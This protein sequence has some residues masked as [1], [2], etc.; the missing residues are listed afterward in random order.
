MS[1]AT[2][3]A[4]PIA[5]LALVLAAVGCEFLD[6]PDTF[7]LPGASVRVSLTDD[8]SQDFASAEV[9]ITR[10]YISRHGDD[11]SVVDLLEASEAPQ[12]VDL[13]RLRDNIETMI[14]ESAVPSGRYDK[15]NIVVDA[16]EVELASGRSFL[17][18]TAS[19]LVEPPGDGGAD[20][21]VSLSEPLV[22]EDG[23]MTL[24][25]VEFV[26]ADSFLLASYPDEPDVVGEIRFEPVLVEKRRHDTPLG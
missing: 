11:A 3:A 26:V 17:D 21:R 14:A 8:P 22:V 16:A 19:R 1:H 4:A 18:G 24:V 13:L 9:S 23:L 7:D 2:R 20:I 5:A 6:Q 25:V 10:V 12:T 15:L